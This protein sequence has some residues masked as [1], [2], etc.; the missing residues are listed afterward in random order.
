MCGI[1]GWLEQRQQI[2]PELLDAMR[3]TLVHRGPDGC[4]SWISPD[5]RAGLA[6]RR[7]SILDLSAAGHQPMTN[8]DETLWLT[9]NGEIYNFQPL[10]DELV[11]RGHR[12]RSRTDSEV[13]LHGFEEWG[14]PGL[15]ARLKGMF[16]FA[17]HDVRTGTLFAA[18]DRFGIKPLLYHH[19]PERFVFGSE[20]KSIVRHPAVPKRLRR[21]ALADYFIYSYVPHPD[22]VYEGIH[23]LPPAHYLELDRAGR[24]QLT[25]Y[26]TLMPG[27]RR[28]PAAEVHERTTELLRRAVGEHLVSDVPV[29]VFLSGGYDSSVVLMHTA[30]QTGVRPSTFSLGFAGSDRSEH[31]AARQIAELLGS[32]HHE[33]VLPRADDLFPLLERLVG[34]YDEPFGVS[35]ML[36]YHHVCELA[37]Q[38]HKV[39]LAGDGGDELMAGYTWYPH[40]HRMRRHWKSW[41]R[42]LRYGKTLRDQF[43]DHYARAQTGVFHHLFV[44]QWTDPLDPELRQ[45]MEQRAYGHFERHFPSA[46][47]PI[48]NVQQLDVSVFMLDNSLQRADLSSMLHSLEVRVPF[49]DHELFEYVHSLHPSC[50]FDPQQNK[51]L[52]RRQ[53]ETAL[54]PRILDRPK[55]GFGFQ[56]RDVMLTAPY[57][58]FINHGELRRRGILAQEVRPE[59][60]SG[61]LALHLVLLE[62]WFR[63]HGRDLES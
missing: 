3:D 23:K 10:R 26:W 54:P 29:G 43:L 51:K 38:T 59:R 28:A 47:H 17:I 5:G 22:T 21:D 14:G 8:E 45:L 2:D 53:L 19:T 34:Q 48:Q 63:T 61:N 39:V 13:L 56:H 44:S 37:A 30:Q 6:H 46:H 7:L 50:Y 55:H 15:L 35:S 58:D 12:F 42:I 25:R 57:L 41:A 11:Q 40:Y 9:F 60:T 18:R 32:D 52:I 24:L 1:V 62:Q 27:S 36:T 16:A 20:L 31:T 33:R 49:L 4:G